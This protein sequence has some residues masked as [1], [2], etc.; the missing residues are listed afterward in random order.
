MFKFVE[1][2]NTRVA[3]H[4]PGKVAFFHVMAGKLHAVFVA[5]I[6]DV[7]CKVFKHKGLHALPISVAELAIP[8]F[9]DKHQTEPVEQI[10]AVR[11]FIKIGQNSRISVSPSVILRLVRKETL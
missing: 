2:H 4:L 5:P 1:R 8:F 7:F 9:F 6:I 3:S 11:F 10:L